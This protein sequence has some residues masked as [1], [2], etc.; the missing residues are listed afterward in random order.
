MLQTIK[1]ILSAQINWA[2]SSY[3]QKLGKSSTM[4]GGTLVNNRKL[5][6]HKNNLCTA[7]QRFELQAGALLKLFIQDHLRISLTLLEVGKIQMKG[8]DSSCQNEE[9]AWRNQGEIEGLATKSKKYWNQKWGTK[10][11]EETWRCFTYYR[12]IFTGS[13]SKLNK[14][15]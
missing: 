14:W 3:E 4:L 10:Y 12:N 9:I 1:C 11:S 2:S 5:L 6:R 8:L 15:R 7:I 13:Y